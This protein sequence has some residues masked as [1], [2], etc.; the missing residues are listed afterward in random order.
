MAEVTQKFNKPKGQEEELRAPQ[1]QKHELKTAAI[2]DF[3]P[4]QFTISNVYGSGFPNR[5]QDRR[6]PISSKY[7]SADAA[8]QY[9]F[10]I[11]KLNFQTGFSL[12]NITNYTNIRLNQSVNV[13]GDQIIDTY[14]VPFTFT[15]FLNLLF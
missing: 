7:F 11:N 14:G 2:L 15:M 1:S 6:M 3:Y 9:S 10:D 4:W 8:A 12:L 13:P 5:P